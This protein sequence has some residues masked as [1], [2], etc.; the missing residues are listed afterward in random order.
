MR[1][2]VV[3][4]YAGGSPSDVGAKAAH[5]QSQGHTEAIAGRA[6]ETEA[7]NG[8]VQEA[9]ATNRVDEVADDSAMKQDALTRAESQDGA[10][11]FGQAGLSDFV[12]LTLTGQEL[13]TNIQNEIDGLG[14]NDIGVV[15]GAGD[16]VVGGDVLGACETGGSDPGDGGGQEETCGRGD[17]VDPSGARDPRRTE[18]SEGDGGG[19][20]ETFG[21]GD[22][23]DPSGARDPRR[24][25]TSEGDGGDPSGARDPRRTEGHTQ[26]GQGHTEA[27]IEHAATDSGQVGLGDFVSLTLTEKDPATNIQNEIVDDEPGE[28]AGDAQTEPLAAGRHG[29]GETGCQEDVGGDELSASLGEEGCVVPSRAPEPV[30]KRE[31]RRRGRERARRREMAKQEFERRRGVIAS[32]PD[33]SVGEILDSVQ[34]LLP[35]AVA[36]L[37]KYGPR[38]P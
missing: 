17:G 18:T 10:T 19:R 6:C 24:T 3:A 25:E 1:L 2:T 21:R 23:G 4:R 5:V 7:G 33:V 28:A 38:S 13:E 15:E 34:G 12:P 16:R 9:S 35:N 31:R 36:F 14:T 30:S 37:R 20:K 11:D 32:Q 27:E 29:G 22:G 8:G 26:R